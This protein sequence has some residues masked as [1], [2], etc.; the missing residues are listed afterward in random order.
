MKTLIK[1]SL[2]IAMAVGI[3]GCG[4]S[5]EST[6]EKFV[7]CV[8]LDGDVKA[9]TKYVKDPEATFSKY[10]IIDPLK[11]YVEK[12]WRKGAFDKVEFVGIERTNY[13]SG[14]SAT[15]E[16]KVL[17]AFSK[18]SI[19]IK[20]SQVDASDTWLVSGLGDWSDFNR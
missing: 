7:K 12:K 18:R 1:L 4:K 9:A 19:Q 13:E 15:V 11:E 6:A 2:V 8:F 17:D 14:N 20:L 5:P 16:L 10:Y 3:A